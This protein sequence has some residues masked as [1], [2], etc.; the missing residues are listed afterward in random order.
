MKEIKIPLT[1]EE[2]IKSIKMSGKKCK[3]SGSTSVLNCHCND[4]HN[5]IIEYLGKK[6]GKKYLYTGN[7]KDTIK[8]RE[9]IITHFS[10]D[11]DEETS[12]CECFVK[13][14]NSEYCFEWIPRKDI[15]HNLKE[16]KN[17]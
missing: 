13:M 6:K 14:A 5:H 1:N 17:G 16:I 15:F 9:V 10:T 8:D 12:S 4:C 11:E 2:R 7:F 3:T